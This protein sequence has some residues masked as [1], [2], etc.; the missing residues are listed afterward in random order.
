[1]EDR[2]WLV[3]YGSGVSILVFFEEGDDLVG[4]DAL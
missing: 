4:S 1:M 2:L 3:A